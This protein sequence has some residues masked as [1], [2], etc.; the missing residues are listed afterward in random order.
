MNGKRCVERDEDLRAV[1]RSCGFL[2]TREMA[3]LREMKKPWI[4]LSQHRE[5]QRE[6]ERE[7]V[8]EFGDLNE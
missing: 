7:M 1:E 4:T 3:W 6:R 2:R 8:G 5:K